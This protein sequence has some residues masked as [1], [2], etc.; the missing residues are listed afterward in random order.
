MQGTSTLK[1]SN[2][3]LKLV[4]MTSANELQMNK[5]IFI[6]QTF[7]YLRRSPTHHLQC[8][9]LGNCASKTYQIIKLWVITS[10]RNT[11]Q[12]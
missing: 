12:L 1:N 8:L 10:F 11:T 2:V 9:Y 5:Y 7:L 3:L 6:S 4:L